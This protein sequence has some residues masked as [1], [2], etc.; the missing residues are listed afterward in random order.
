[1]H[2]F[3]F[4]LTADFREIMEVYMYEDSYQQLAKQTVCSSESTEN[5]DDDLEGKGKREGSLRHHAHNCI[6]HLSFLVF[7]FWSVNLKKLSA[8]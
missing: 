8:L 3:R 4:N 5:F 6:V 7:Q 2:H 1:M